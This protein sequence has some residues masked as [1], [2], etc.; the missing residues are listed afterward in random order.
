MFHFLFV[1]APKR[2]PPQRLTR[3]ASA[4]TRL[5]K[6]HAKEPIAAK[7]KLRVIVSHRPTILNEAQS[8]QLFNS[9][10]DKA[11]V[12]DSKKKQAT[13]SSSSPQSLRQEIARIQNSLTNNEVLLVQ[14]GG[15]YELYEWVMPEKHPLDSL[16]SLL[17]LQIAS[18]GDNRRCGFP[19]ANVDRYV[20]KLIA[21]SI[22]VAIVDQ[23]GKDMI[24][25]GKNYTR[26]VARIVTNG[27]PIF[28]TSEESNDTQHGNCF[29]LSLAVLPSNNISDQK[30]GLSWTD[31][32]TGEFFVVESQ[33]STLASDLTRI[34]PSEIVTLPEHLLPTSIRRIIREKSEI[35]GIQI[36]HRESSLDPAT[37]IKHCAHVQA[38]LDQMNTI[39]N[40][41]KATDFLTEALTITRGDGKNSIKLL[42]QSATHTSLLA[43]GSLFA[44]L[45][46]LFCGLEP[47]FNYNSVSSRS[48][49]AGIGIGDTKGIMHID[50]ASM[51][52]LE[53]VKTIREHEKKGSLMSEINQTKTSQ[54]E[55]LLISRL[56]SPSTNIQEI[57]RRQNLIEYF[58][59][60]P[61]SST[62]INTTQQHLSKIRDLERSLQRLHLNSAK[63]RDVMNLLQSLEQVDSLRSFLLNHELEG[64]SLDKGLRAELLNLVKRFNP[65]MDLVKEYKNLLMVAVSAE[66]A[67]GSGD[68][69]SRTFQF[70]SFG[71][72]LMKSRIWQAGMIGEGISKHVDLW[73][74]KLAASEKKI[75]A[76]KIKL[77]KQYG[78]EVELVEDAKDG[79]C[80]SMKNRLGV[81]AAVESDES[82]AI[83][84]RQNLLTKKK[85]RHEEWTELFTAYKSIQ[86]QLV[87]AEMRVF[88][89][90]CQK[91]RDKTPEIVGTSE[92]VAELDVTVSMAF[93]A[94]QWHYVRP[95]M[96]D[97]L[98]VLELKDSRHPVVEN[99]QLLRSNTF[100]ANDLFLD[101]ESR[102]W[103]MTGPNMGGKSTFLRQV[104][105]IA[106]MA[107]AGLYVPASSAK[108]GILDAVYSRVGASDNL[109]ANQSTF[110][111][112]ME[113]TA[114]IVNCATGRSLVIMDEVGRGTS[115]QDGLAIACGVL[116]RVL[117]VNKSLCLFATHYH[118]LPL[119]LSHH[120]GYDGKSV[121][122]TRCVRTAINFLPDGQF[123]YCYSIE[124]GVSESSY[125]IEAARLAGMPSDVIE[126]ST[127]LQRVLMEL[128]KKDE[129]AFGKLLHLGGKK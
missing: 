39:R 26:A 40:S 109:A 27:T 64:A 1:Q 95:Q 91:I 6:K 65:P 93:V 32:T 29:L 44:Y 84:H 18:S 19:I 2:F 92:A 53:I 47:H 114:N 107:Q 99:M 57:Q 63:P 60:L 56:K 48:S 37:C 106:I 76:L 71:S 80:I 3:A 62:L 94:S 128:R 69:E 58:Y 117:K 8:L 110:R 33:E 100:T 73:K 126:V 115:S 79:P 119:V 101:P 123:S 20:A 49:T 74:K 23:V 17:E 14:V 70:S 42:G 83:L 124:E 43:A 88:E 38:R 125:G 85:Y 102:V 16:A 112:E 113:E 54:G 7:S 34:S 31:I 116:E 122:G 96:V 35:D 81:N 89:E 59:N 97:E 75:E 111:V 66:E 45:N 129:Q 21:Q 87:Q 72:K 41:L 104:A 11:T 108:M 78:V 61:P 67:N 10:P 98:C 22:K 50:A 13:D 46:E 24:S 127:K 12:K 103:I 15:F 52:S 86:E 55:R 121:D 28:S 25:Q 9:L 120:L 82:I 77:S 90:A 118:E 105:L 68:T 4:L 30:I 36:S 51:T 5:L